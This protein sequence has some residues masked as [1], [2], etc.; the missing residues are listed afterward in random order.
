[1]HQ[2][3]FMLDEEEPRD[4]VTPRDF[5][6]PDSPAIAPEIAA[7]DAALETVVA[8]AGETWKE[9][10]TRIARAISPGREVTGEDI[11]LAC[12]QANIRPHHSNAWGGFIYGL[13]TAGILEGTGRYVNMK[14]KGSHGRK[15]Q[16]YRRI[17]AYTEMCR[18]TRTA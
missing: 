11:R 18:A 15:T 16:V 8:H 5:F 7:R 1:M 12:E 3:G 9:T 2:F 13:V 4:V 6:I 10:A 14:A 17:E